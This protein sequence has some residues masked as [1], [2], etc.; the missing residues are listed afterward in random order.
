M[1]K[2]FAK[3]RKSKVLDIAFRQMTLAIDTVTDLRKAITAA[4]KGK[5][6]E[7]KSC[8]ERLFV[9]EREIDDLRRAVFAE[10]TRGSL[11]SKDREDIMHLVKR[12]DVMADFVKDSARTLLILTQAEVPEEIWNLFVEMARDLV[13]CASTLRKSI[14]K[15]GTNLAEARA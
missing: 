12:L 8:V 13:E 11:S 5:V 4:S 2:W 10:L 9:V 6:N 3:R 7:T 15:L 14:E 1:E